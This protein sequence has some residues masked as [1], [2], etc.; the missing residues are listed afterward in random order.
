MFW[1]SNKKYHALFFFLKIRKDVTK[2][3]AAAVVIGALKGNIQDEKR[4]KSNLV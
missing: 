4:K 1:L 2:S 3:V